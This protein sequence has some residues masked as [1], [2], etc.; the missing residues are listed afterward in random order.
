V[1]DAGDHAVPSVRVPVAGTT[2]TDRIVRRVEATA[3]CP[4]CPW[5]ASMTG[6]SVADVVAFLNARWREHRAE[7]HRRTH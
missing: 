6:D 4:F 7:M 3:H 5:V 2:M 1:G